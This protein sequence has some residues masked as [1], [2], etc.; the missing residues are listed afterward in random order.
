MGDVREIYSLRTA[1]EIFAFEQV[2]E[3]RDDH[4]SR[5][6]RRRNVALVASIDAR[7]DRISI[8]N[9]LELHGLRRLAGEPQLSALGVVAYPIAR[10]RR[11]GRAQQ[12]FGLDEREPCERL[13]GRGD[14]YEAAQP[15]G[16]G[17]LD[18]L[19]ARRRIRGE[20][21]RGAAAERRGDRALQA[22]LDVELAQRQTRTLFGECARGRGRRQATRES[23]QWRASPGPARLGH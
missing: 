10:N 6:L 18:Q 17:A 4:F 2:W 21:S 9:E 3:H 5:E 7:D 13:T 15:R 16:P 11:A 23:T 22:W 1:L 19:E 14:D 20:Q 8:S 12:V